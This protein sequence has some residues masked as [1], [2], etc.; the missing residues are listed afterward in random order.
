[1]NDNPKFLDKNRNIIRDTLFSDNEEKEKEKEIEENK[2]PKNFPFNL[3][4]Q[5]IIN[6][7]ESK[8]KITTELKKLIDFV[9]ERYYYRD[10]NGNRIISKGELIPTPFQKLEKMNEDIKKY[11]IRKLMRKNSPL[12]VKNSRNKN[13]CLDNNLNAINS[14][15]SISQRKIKNYFSTKKYPTI[16]VGKDFKKGLNNYKIIHNKTVQKDLKLSINNITE[17]NN[18]KNK[19]ENDKVC[20]SETFNVNKTKYFYD[21]QFNQ[22]NFWKAKIAYPQTL[23]KNNIKNRIFENNSRYKNYITE[24]NKRKDENNFRNI[25]S[26]INNN[27][28]SNNFIRNNTS[29]SYKLKSL[30]KKIPKEKKFSKDFIKYDLIQFNMNQLIK[31]DQNHKDKIILNMRKAH[32]DFKNG[33]SMKNK[34][35]SVNMDNNNLLK[36]Y[37]YK[38]KF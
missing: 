20:L 14:L 8:S 30:P 29:K 4:Y 1:M 3:E 15:N 38:N 24:Y 9:R 21:S 34:T 10:I 12:I 22:I 17:Q 27:E 33:K 13:L 37:K 18:T 11:Y 32:K 25:L 19:Y 6:I 23:S 28:K 36:L 2:F 26:R 5:K 35:I 16:N 7:N 31:Q